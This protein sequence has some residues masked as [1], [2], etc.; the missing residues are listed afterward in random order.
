MR[1]AAWVRRNVIAVDVND[2]VCEAETL[3]QRHRI[4]HLP[5]LQQGKLVGILADEDLRAARPPAATTPTV[6]ESQA[7]G[8]HLRM[9]E[10]MA[11]DPLTVAPAT[12]LAQAA[13]LMRDRNISALPVV[14]NQ[15]L[16]GILTLADL[17]ELLESLLLDDGD[18]DERFPEGAVRSHGEM[19]TERGRHET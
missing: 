12:P 2:S 16:V 6:R 5:V 18:A 10:V 14:R 17:F 7:A 1:V 13:R 15:H 3:M 9:D 8:N 19:A 11:R 4:D